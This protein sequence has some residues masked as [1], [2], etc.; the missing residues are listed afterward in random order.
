MEYG[1]NE[2]PAMVGGYAKDVMLFEAQKH[3]LQN[4]EQSAARQYLF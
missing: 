3:R 1:S 4:S 2:C